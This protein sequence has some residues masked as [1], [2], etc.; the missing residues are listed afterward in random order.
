M[1][2]FKIFKDNTRKTQ[3]YLERIAFAAGESTFIGIVIGGV[4]ADNLDY[5]WLVILVGLVA[6][7]VLFALAMFLYLKTNKE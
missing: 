7:L 4:V 1:G 2:F 5:R 6:S 3:T